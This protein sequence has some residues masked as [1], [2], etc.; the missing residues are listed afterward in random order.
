MGVDYKQLRFLIVDDFPEMRSSLRGM[1]ETFGARNVMDTRNGKETIALLEK[2]SFDIILCD[3][4]LGE[5]K[6]GQHILEEA[7][8]RNLIKYS[9]VFMMITAETTVAMVMGA[10]EYEPDGYLTKPFNKSVLKTRLDKLIERKSTFEMVERALANEDHAKVI[11]LCD[12]RVTEDGRYKLEFLKLKCESLIH[13]GQYRK[14][15]D[16]LD[17]LLAGRNITWANLCLGQIHFYEKNFIHAKDIFQNLV[18]E[19]K[20]YIPGY[21]W[22]AKTMIAMGETNE[23]QTV[24]KAAIDL[25]PNAILRH[26][27]L[28]EVAIRNNNLDV[29]ERSLKSAV[30]M[31]KYS[32]YKNTG[33]YTT[34]AKV[35]ADKGAPIESVKILNEARKEFTNDA[36]ASIDLAVS[37][38]IIY[39]RM[40]RDEEASKSL[41]QAAML[42]NTLTKKVSTDV[43]LNYARLCYELGHTEQG[44]KA[45][46]ELV[47]AH[48]EDE[49]IMDKAQA[50]FADL[51]K[52]SEGNIIIDD[53]KKHVKDINKEGVRLA[54]EGKL[55]EAIDLFEKASKGLPNNMAISLN[56]AQALILYLQ[57]NG[58]E[59]NLLARAC[60]YLN[61][62]KEKNPANS[63]FQQLFTMYKQVAGINQ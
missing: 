45:M 41:E 43:S 1:L 33:D 50:L 34:L 42:Q 61:R 54:N 8:H 24:L 16:I 7:K 29:A 39:K 27:K 14:A 63:R 5:G 12:E 23:A 18:Q 49:E 52:Q 62:V 19:H 3:Y 32:C 21:D 13:T 47:K 11:A 48:I 51:G 38:G 35:M 40:G 59:D 10:V 2:K 57:K 17:S 26:K 60:N 56:A 36:D 31:G 15:A 46:Q 37:E 6:N 58:R 25:S 30:K 9:T 4:N 20:N 53:I 22:L 55:E 28:A 44:D